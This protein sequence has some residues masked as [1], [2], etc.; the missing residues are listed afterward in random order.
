MHGA[1][2]MAR[3]SRFGRLPAMHAAHGISRHIVVF[4][5]VLGAF[6]SSLPGLFSP[7]PAAAASAGYVDTDVLNLRTEPG[8]WATVLDKMWYGSYITVLDGPTGDG[9]YYVDYAGT[10]GWAYGGYLLVDGAPGWAA[11][12]E[13]AAPSVGAAGGSAWVNT[14]RLNVRVDAST[15]S[16][17]M[18]KLSLGAEVW[19]TGGAVNGFVPIDL[20][21]Q[22]GWVWSDYLSWDGPVDPGPER[23]IDIDRNS[24]TVTLYVGDEAIASY[25]AALGWD[26]SAEG[27]YA[28][29]IGTYYVYGKHEG[30]TW[31]DWGQAYIMYW[32]GFDP[33]RVNGFH[34][35]SMN[36]NG[37]VLKNGD[38][39]T[40]GCVALAPDAAAELFNF[41]YEGMRVEVHW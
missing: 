23:W 33:S 10:L 28:T 21:G 40:G 16:W 8:T 37:R 5:I 17:V 32:V 13:E 24:Q 30:L 31:T 26:D 41:A 27:F 29:A 7:A 9:W 4:A 20:N 14:D 25:W 35:Y 12:P 19:V 18:D 11:W 39:P 36:E 3:R 22:L 34:S 38:G 15:E 2:R 1:G 6:A